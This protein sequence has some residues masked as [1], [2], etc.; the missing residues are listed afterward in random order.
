V[1]HQKQLDNI[2]KQLTPT[3]AAA[4]AFEACCGRSCDEM[5]AIVAAQPRQAVMALPQAYI[6]RS[7]GLYLLSLC[8]GTFFWKSLA[9]LMLAG[10]RYHSA[11]A[12]ESAKQLG[13]LDA[14]LLE[15]CNRLGVDVL[16]V[17]KLGLVTGDE[18]F[19]EFADPALTDEYIE[20]FLNIA[21]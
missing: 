14:A 5:D 21:Q 1:K 6:Q 8:Y 19:V 9:K 18:S 16:A 4:M 12:E 11:A 15:V 13:S 17:K 3:Q 20:I 7:M 2:Y 10:H